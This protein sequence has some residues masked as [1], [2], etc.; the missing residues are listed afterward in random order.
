MTCTKQDKIIKNRIVCF[1]FFSFSFDSFSVLIK[2]Q[3][4]SKIKNTVS[5]ACCFYQLLLFVNRENILLEFNK[6]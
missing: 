6:I 3:P 4:T 5:S 1:I 2:K